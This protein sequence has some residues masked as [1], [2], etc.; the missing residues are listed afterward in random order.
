MAKRKL[1]TLTDKEIDLLQ[2]AID[3]ARS[4]RGITPL[5]TSVD[6]FRDMDADQQAPEVYVAKPQSGSIPAMTAA[7]VGT[8]T[9]NADDYDA[10]G[11]DY[12]DIYKITDDNAGEPSIT[13]VNRDVRVFNVSESEINA[14]DGYLVVK[15]DKFGRWLAEAGGSGGHTVIRFRVV[16]VGSFQS[17]LSQECLS[18]VAVVLEVSCS[19]SGVS[20][21]DEVTIWDPLACW[22][23]LPIDI[24]ENTAGMA[25]KM[26][27]G[28]NFV[29]SQ[30]EATGTGT[31]TAA[32][33]DT[34]C[35]WVVQNLCC[36][37]E[38]YP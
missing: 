22:F 4:A 3:E 12:C 33:A 24:L 14:G 28:S 10:P 6:T 17:L 25:V 16:S 38:V 9:G 21:G 13:Q 34:S 15:R 1:K 2:W 37:E 35:Y 27:I 32:T 11:E 8:G 18:V 26:E 20:V 5:R 31:G 19:S 30:C 7:G 29:P 36:A 23:N